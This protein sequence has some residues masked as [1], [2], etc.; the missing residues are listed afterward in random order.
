MTTTLAAAIWRRSQDSLLNQAI[1]IVAGTLLLAIS[2]KVQVPFWPIPMTMQTFVVLLLGVVYGPRL[3]TITGLLYL[4]E[5]A[6]GLPV[7]AQGSG[8]VYLLGPTGGYLFGFVFAMYFVGLAA[9]RGWDRSVYRMFLAMLI[10]EAI[11]FSLGV[12]WLSAAI[13]L[14][15]AIDA[16]LTPFLLAELF[17][18]ALVAVT[19]PLAWKRFAA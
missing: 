16:G 9:Q 19:V 6:V 8:M 13:G 15:K 12:G 14:A 2:A 17:K 1:L 4:A 7:F 10:G 3:G 5:G 11:I 18:M